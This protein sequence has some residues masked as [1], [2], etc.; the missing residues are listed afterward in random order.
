MKFSKIGLTVLSGRV[1]I[2]VKFACKIDQY[3]LD[4]FYVSNIQRNMLVPVRGPFGSTLT[5]VKEGQCGNNPM[6][7]LHCNRATEKEWWS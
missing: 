2:L 3:L 6:I 7:A 4:L 5:L 1:L